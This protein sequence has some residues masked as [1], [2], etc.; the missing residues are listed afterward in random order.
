MVYLDYQ[1][2]ELKQDIIIDGIY[3]IHY[4]EYT[5]DFAY[6]GEYHNF[7][8]IVYADKKKL[9][10]TAG[11]EELMLDVGE[12]YI[13]R[14]NEFHSIRCDGT[15]AANSVILSFDCNCSEL[16]NIA[17]MRITCTAEERRLMGNIIKEAVEAFDTPLG[18]PYI[19]RLEK[20]QHCDFG[21][22][23][24]V[25]LYLEMLLILLIRGNKGKTKSVND[26]GNKELLLICDYLEKNVDKKLTFDDIMLHLNLSSSVIKRLFSANMD[27][28]VMEYFTRL[29]VDAAKSMIRENE[30]N[31]TEISSRLGFNNSQYFTTVFKRVSGMTP[32]EYANSVK[33]RFI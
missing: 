9:L 25:K 17:G 28:G 22:E 18:S 31:F 29:K 14:P 19:S 32:S 12:L 27:C 5:K 11:N 2:T 10:I 3:T 16:L 23:Q 30:Y 8:E 1:R 7:W 26:N 6:S 33:S 20:S 4:F 24:M 13:H 21:C 15:N